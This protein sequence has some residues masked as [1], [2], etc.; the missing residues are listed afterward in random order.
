MDKFLLPNGFF[1]Y[2]GEY[3]IKSEMI[4]NALIDKFVCN[5]YELIFPS[6]IEFSEEKQKKSFKIFDSVSNEIV[7]LRNDI[8]P[9]INRI[10]SNQKNQ[11]IKRIC[12]AGE[13]FTS[14]PS[15]IRHARQITQ[16]GCEIIGSPSIYADIEILEMTIETLSLIGINNISIDFCYPRLIEH[17]SAYIGI[18][19]KI[20][21]D[22]ILTRDITPL[23]FVCDD[24]KII[25]F[26]NKILKMEH[27]Y[28]NI[29]DNFKSIFI[30]NEYQEELDEISK[31][32]SKVED[33]FKGKINITL[34]LLEMRDFEFH[35]GICFNIYNEDNS[36]LV[37]KGGR[38]DTMN[39]LPAV[40]VTMYGDMIIKSSEI[41]MKKNRIYVTLDSL[42]SYMDIVDQESILI[43]SLGEEFDNIEYAKK[44]GCDGI[45]INGE[46][47]KI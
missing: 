25:K 17:L 20:F 12:Y 10:V 2:T 32:L 30:S 5:G 45:I 28:S 6:F 40:G 13:V 3:A 29:I 24:K 38:Y 35:K 34:D 46:L 36:I 15:E 14:N 33:K 21:K 43:R 26:F 23:L 47:K 7:Y 27:I 8:T 9:Q 31:F 11:S 22:V 4:R 16:Y 19:E 39:G 44:I 42:D 1:D 37:A 41:C 18:D